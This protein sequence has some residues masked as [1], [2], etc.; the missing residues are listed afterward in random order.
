MSVAAHSG[1]YEMLQ[2]YADEYFEE[3][4]KEEA[5]SMELAVW[6]V[7]T[8]R[9]EP[10]SDLVLRKCREDFSRAMREQHIK[11]DQGQPVRAKHAA[12]RIVDQKQRT[13]WADIR[14]APR[15]HMLTAFQQRREQIVGDCRQLDRDAAYYNKL[16]P[17]N[18][19]I[20]LV[21]DFTED[22]E[23]G[24]FAVDDIGAKP[25]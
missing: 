3:T 18:E 2:H 24:R 15:A 13:F 8:F 22:V 4:G 1:Y 25:R 6:A 5:T 14:R 23:E 7:K 9:W 20:Q 16:H 10:P 11:D 21:F 17:E 12:R 19:P